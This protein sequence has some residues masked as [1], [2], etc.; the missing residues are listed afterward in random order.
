MTKINKECEK[1]KKECVDNKSFFIKKTQSFVQMEVFFYI[2]KKDEK[3]L[4]VCVFTV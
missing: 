1:S 2:C 3:F 4:F